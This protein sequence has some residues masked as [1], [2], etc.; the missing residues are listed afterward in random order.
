MRDFEDL[1]RPSNS[2]SKR[3][4][5]YGAVEQHLRSFDVAL[6][7]QELGLGAQEVREIVLAQ[8]ENQ[9]VRARGGDAA[10][11]GDDVRVAVEKE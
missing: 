1:L 5:I 2:T 11:Q 9:V 3:N 7:P 4:A 6:L 10:E 8:F